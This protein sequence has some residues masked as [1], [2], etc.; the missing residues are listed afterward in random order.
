MYCYD[1][2]VFSAEEPPAVVPM[3]HIKREWKY[4]L[5]LYT[6]RYP[7]KSAFTERKAEFKRNFILI[8]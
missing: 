7:Y 4:Q 8:Y 6:V 1:S 5:F 3:I 2:C